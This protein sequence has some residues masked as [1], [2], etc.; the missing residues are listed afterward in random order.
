MARVLINMSSQPAGVPAGVARFG[1]DLSRRLAERGSHDYVFRSQWSAG[2]LPPGLVANAELDVIPPLSSYFREFGTQALLGSRHYPASRYDLVFNLDPLG[3]ASGGRSRMMIVHDIYYRSHG[4][5]YAAMSGLKAR[6]QRAKQHAIHSAMIARSSLIV[7]ISEST[8]ADV[9]RH[10]PSAASR[11]RTI[12]SDS[13]MGQVSPGMLP[14]GL[15]PNRFFLAVAN[16]TPNKNFG[17]L[18][19]AFGRLA[20][21]HPGIRLVHVGG[22]ADETFQKGLAIHGAADRLTRLRGIDD[23]TLAALYRDALALVVPSLIEGFCLPVLEAQRLD[24]PV[25]F[26]NVSATGEIGGNG[27]IAFDPMDVDA[28]ETSMRRILREDGLRDAMRASGREN[29]LRFSWDRTVGE[30][31]TAI[32]DALTREK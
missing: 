2:Q 25:V 1:M 13:T 31:E 4:V 19:D 27:G 9:R 28:L 12:L 7:G 18:A 10:F 32:Q 21:D 17:V 5:Y 16:V 11:V 14:D 22:D 8:S 23:A 29:A 20:A 15:E 3:M 6:L 30:Y 26:S 24:C